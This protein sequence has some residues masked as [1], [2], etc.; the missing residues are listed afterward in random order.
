MRLVTLSLLFLVTLSVL[1]SANWFADLF[2]GQKVF[3]DN[4]KVLSADQFDGWEIVQH[5]GNESMLYDVSIDGDFVCFV[6]KFSGTQ[7]VG[8]VTYDQPTNL[9]L[10]FYG[11]IIYLSKDVDGKFC[12]VLDESIN[13]YRFGESTTVIVSSLNYNSSDTNVS[14]KSNGE[15]FVHLNVSTAAPYDTLLFYA[16]FDVNTSTVKD[17]SKYALNGTI[18]GALA[19]LNSTGPFG[20]AEWFGMGN[21]RI[22]F[23]ETQKLKHLRNLTNFSV[24]VWVKLTTYGESGRG[25]I[26]AKSGAL[27][28]NGW[29][30]Y[31][32]NNTGSESVVFG[33]DFPFTDLTYRANNSYLRPNNWTHILVSWNESVPG[34]GVTIYI[35]GVNITNETSTAGSGIRGG[36]DNENFSIGGITNNVFDADAA[37]DEVM[38]F[39]KSLTTAEAVAIYNNQSPRFLGSG[40]MTFTNI[41]VSTAGNENRI[42]ISINKTQTVFNSNLMVSV[43]DGPFVNI[44]SGNATTYTFS[45][46]PGELNVT[47]KFSAGNSSKNTFYSP[48]IIGNITLSA[49]NETQQ[50]GISPSPTL[51]YS[52]V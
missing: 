37:I 32:S 48:I 25:V 26:V 20:T 45:K 10:S 7:K 13:Y 5:S 36:D 22:D 17:Y 50:P 3:V 15:T 42:N 9:K 41:N 38:I 31:G 33:V 44:S 27:T 51:Y 8:N 49:W 24:S 11:N 21:S 18:I 34:K 16:P 43:N 23:S 28:T 12:Y 46:N 39:N 4:N 14:Q 1:V 52:C 6:P 29:L 2:S 40:N 47:F 35:N 30:L 19:Q